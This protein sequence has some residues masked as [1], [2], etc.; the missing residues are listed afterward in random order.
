MTPAIPKRR[1]LLDFAVSVCQEYRDEG[2]SITLRQL[3]YQGVSRK[4]LPSSQNA[5]NALKV[6][7]A[8]ARLDGSFPLWAIVDR[9][10]KVYPSAQTHNDC[11]LDRALERS[12]EAVR[13]L[14]G[15]L[16]VRARWFGQPNHV[17]VLYEKESLAGIFE[18]TCE[19]LGVGTF[20][21]HGDAS[22]AGLY[23]WLRQA[24]VAH[25]IDNPKGSRDDK[26]SFHRGLAKQSTILYFGDHDPTG[27]R[28]PRTLETTL[29]RFMEITQKPLPLQFVRVGITLDQARSMNLPPFWAKESAGADYDR[30]VEEFGTEEAWELD[31][32]SPSVL[33]KLV[34]VE[35]KTR[36][37]N[38]LY[39][40]L[41]AEVEARRIEM[42]QRM[43]S[44]DWH[45][46]ATAPL[47][48]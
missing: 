5:Y 17:T 21:C 42:R 15:S 33:A 16:L 45:A 29:R 34:Q 14:P 28:I 9:S 27:V 18:D 7:L 47:D 41:Q 2:W 19:P 23:D 6:A 24:A 48:E 30:Y 37:D 25:G 4:T 8:K 36:F 31:A 43:R 38:A 12:A 22:H 32:L 26:G 10:R 39:L 13:A 46:R 3:Y 1:E 35:V 40:R 11:N 44:P 20:A